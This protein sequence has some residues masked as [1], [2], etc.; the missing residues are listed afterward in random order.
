[1]LTQV[2]MQ[3]LNLVYRFCCQSGTIPF[4]WKNGRISLKENQNILYKYGMWLLLLPCLVVKICMLFQKQDINDL[5]LNGLFFL[6]V[7]G[8]I[9][10]QLTVQ[11]YQKEFVQLINQTLHMNLCWGKHKTVA[12]SK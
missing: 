7:V 3:V 10:F 6:D 11:L 5:L 1:M 4:C 12:I 9:T 2:E 8:N